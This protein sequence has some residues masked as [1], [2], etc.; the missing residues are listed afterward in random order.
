MH[1][2]MTLIMTVVFNK[3]T[4]QIEGVFIP[5]I[6]CLLGWSYLNCQ[7]ESNNQSLA[8]IRICSYI[9]I[10]MCRAKPKRHLEHFMN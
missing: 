9:H 10:K 5:K 1:I 8:K 4:S 6:T 2:F 7:P 3:I